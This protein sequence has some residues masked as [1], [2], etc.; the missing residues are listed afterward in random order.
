MIGRIRDM[1]LVYRRL[2]LVLFV[3]LLVGCNPGEMFLLRTLP[4]AVKSFPNVPPVASYRMDV[5][6]DVEN[7]TLTGTE[8]IEY[9]NTTNT[10]FS[11]LVFHL[12]LNAFRSPE[13]IFLT[14]AQDHRGFDW[15]P[16]NPGWIR[17]DSIALADGSPLSL[18][19][20][21]DGTLARAL[22]PRPVNPG[23]TIEIQI[24]FEAKLPKV[25]AR[26]GFAFDAAGAPFFMVGQWFPKL[27][28]WQDDGWNAYPFHANSEFYAD[29]G[30]YDVSITL[31]AEYVTGGVGLVSRSVDSPDGTQTVQYYAEGVIDFAWTA[32]PNFHKASRFSE[33]TEV[34]YLYL[35][36]HEWTVSRVLEAASLSVGYFTRWYGDYPYP[37][38]TIVDVPDD[39]EGAGGMEYP[40]LITAG[41]M[42]ILGIP[43]EISELGWER[44]LESVVS[45]EIGHQWWQSIVAFNEAEEPWL[46]EGITDYAS[47]RLMNRMFGPGESIL[48]AGRYKAGAFDMRRLEYLI[49]PDLPMSGAAWEYASLL[50]YGTAVYSKAVV[51][52]FTLERVL[53]EPVMTQVMK[54]FYETYRFAHPTTQDFWELAEQVS[55]KDL[56]WFFEGLVY[57]EGTLNYR[58]D[59][60]EDHSLTI[61]R[62]GELAIPTFIEVR[63]ADGRQNLEPWDGEDEVLTLNY[64]EGDE[65][66][67]AEVDPDRRVLVDLYWA[68]NGMT[69]R[70]DLNDWA[71]LT[72][73]ILHLFQNL[74]LALGG[75]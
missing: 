23:E 51:S 73:R 58:V 71:A 10:P 61:V 70:A 29:F 16:E 1:W 42:N 40:T 54:R 59:S 9:R 69:R 39:G 48:E 2:A 5:R 31:P 45:H 21:E 44:S 8:I 7:K 49:N 64:P 74:A 46:D 72:T 28:V 4:G 17:V 75:I 22:L 18:E 52:L 53:G 13:S 65:I 56:D 63:F 20:I 3:L 11:D 66:I 32:S 62:E 19:E 38:L 43:A 14:E 25:F 33:G 34:L 6:L 35:P 67:K 50:E 15:D 68:D 60:L 12:Y 36:E 47:V 37:R 41:A 55:G 57:G 26:T 27:G 30:T 24:L